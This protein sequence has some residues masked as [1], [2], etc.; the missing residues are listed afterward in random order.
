MSIGMDFDASATAAFEA[1]YT[2][3]ARVEAGMKWD[4]ASNST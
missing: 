1:A 3:T 2:A 4:K